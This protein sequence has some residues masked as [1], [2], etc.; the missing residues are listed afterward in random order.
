MNP[1]S[2]PILHVVAI[3]INTH[4][5]MSIVE[6]CFESLH[7]RGHIHDIIRRVAE[8]TSQRDTL[9][10]D[11][12]STR[13]WVSETTTVG[14]YFVH[15]YFTRVSFMSIFSSLRRAALIPVRTWR[16]FSLT[17]GDT[18]SYGIMSRTSS[19]LSRYSANRDT[20]VSIY[21]RS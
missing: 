16:R 5:V 14:I 3:R 9:A 11:T 7:D 2:D 17:K 6:T 13:P 8:V 4:I 15:G 18:T 12:P 21:S 20:N 10:Y 1:L 19:R